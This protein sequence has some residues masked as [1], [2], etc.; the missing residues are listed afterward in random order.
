MKTF[1]LFI[2]TTVS[3]F[4]G[5]IYEE[6]LPEEL[7]SQLIQ[8]DFFDSEKESLEI[9]KKETNVTFIT[10]IEVEKNSK[11][12]T[13]VLCFC[14]TSFGGY[15]HVGMMMYYQNQEL[16]KHFS[17]SNLT[18]MIYEN[19]PVEKRR[20]DIENVLRAHIE[21]TCKNPENVEE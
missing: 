11:D 7:Y 5:N 17:Q 4:A 18:N 10:K 6:H 1:C 20:K 2:I 13:V 16:I 9:T 8:K 19:F 14:L 3:I 21:M 12:E 15:G